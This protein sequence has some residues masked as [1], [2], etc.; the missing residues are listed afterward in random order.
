[1]G[2]HEQ[3][4]A[5]MPM[6]VTHSFTAPAPGIG[7]CDGFEN[8]PVRSLTA[9]KQLT[10]RPSFFVFTSNTTFALRPFFPRTSLNHRLRDRDAEARV[11]FL[12]ELPRFNG[13]IRAIPNFSWQSKMLLPKVPTSLSP[14]HPHWHLIILQASSS[15][16]P[17]S[18]N[19][20]AFTQWNPYTCNPALVS[21]SQRTWNN[22]AFFP[23]SVLFPCCLPVYPGITQYTDCF[24]IFISHS[25][26][27]D[28]QLEMIL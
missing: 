24:Q 12:R 11:T 8:T 28:T 22:T 19:I 15:P 18:H 7:F 13:S 4:W 25:A 27:R 5:S 21:A 10:E 17:F 14:S 16:F 3:D 23:F 2:G 20:D 26:T 1:M 6:S 9:G